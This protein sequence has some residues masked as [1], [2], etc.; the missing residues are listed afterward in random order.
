MVLLFSRH[1]VALDYWCK[2]HAQGQR[3]NLS[4]GAFSTADVKF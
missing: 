3:V 2:E 1:I 4:L